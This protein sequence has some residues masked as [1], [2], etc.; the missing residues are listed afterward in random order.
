MDMG[1]KISERSAEPLE[2]QFLFQWINVLIQGFNLI[3]FRETFSALHTWTKLLDVE[4]IITNIEKVLK[5]V[6][7]NEF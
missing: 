4:P 2:V 3:L 5:F 1:H 6:N 7:F